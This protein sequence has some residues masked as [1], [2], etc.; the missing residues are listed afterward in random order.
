MS[1]SVSESVDR[2]QVGGDLAD[3]DGWR[4]LWTDGSDGV[5][6][7]CQ[8]SRRGIIMKCDD[9]DPGLSSPI[10]E[11]DAS[12]RSPGTLI[13]CSWGCGDYNVL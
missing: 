10:D 5:Q 13:P 2:A 4:L 6:Y 11:V 8:L 1:G 12:R 3:A 9:D 7:S